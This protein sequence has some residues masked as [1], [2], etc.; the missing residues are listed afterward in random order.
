MLNMTREQA[1]LVL[2]LRTG[3][4]RGIITDFGEMYLNKEC[5]LSGCQ[6]IDSIPYLLACSVMQAAVQYGDV[7]N[8]CQEKHNLVLLRFSQLVKARTELLTQN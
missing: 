4:L 5:P 2:S 7:F 1:S 6:E 3:K 8:S